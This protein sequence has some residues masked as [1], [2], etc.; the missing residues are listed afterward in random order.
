[1]DCQWFTRVTLRALSVIAG[2]AL[3]CLPLAAS[4]ENQLHADHAVPLGATVRG[5]S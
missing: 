3:V 4:A 5:S 1:M 2:G